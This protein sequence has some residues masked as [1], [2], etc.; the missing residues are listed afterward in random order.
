MN[1]Q[2]VMEAYDLH[3]AIEASS[4]A[5]TDT[6]EVEVLNPEAGEILGMMPGSKRYVHFATR[7]EEQC[8]W[9]VGTRQC[10]R[11]VKSGTFRHSLF[12]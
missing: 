1:D 8:V 2:L 7:D 11:Q 12:G 4:G 5:N 6:E 10:V 9:D 3:K